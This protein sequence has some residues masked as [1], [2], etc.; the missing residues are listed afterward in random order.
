[1]KYE[2]RAA[3]T[4]SPYTQASTPSTRYSADSEDLEFTVLMLNFYKVA[5]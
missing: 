4:S 2:T 5:F 3:P 1:M